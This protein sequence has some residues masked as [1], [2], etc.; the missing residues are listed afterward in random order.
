MRAARLSQRYAK[1]SEPIIKALEILQNVSEFRCSVHKGSIN[2]ESDGQ[3]PT[4]RTRS[5]RGRANGFVIRLGLRP[6]HI[7]RSPVTI[8]TCAIGKWFHSSI[9]QLLPNWALSEPILALLACRLSDGRG[10]SVCRLS[11]DPACQVCAR[12]LGNEDQVC[13]DNSASSA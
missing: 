8:Y 4:Q 10:L 12:S 7:N 5:R 6:G 11:C 13:A 3:P 1:S 9:I 2:C